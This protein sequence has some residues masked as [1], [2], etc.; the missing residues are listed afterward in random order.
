VEI[1]DPRIFMLCKI[2]VFG[3]LFL[4]PL[5]VSGDFFA[6]SFAVILFDEH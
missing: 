5:T 3:V 2:Y 4:F 6:F 1:A